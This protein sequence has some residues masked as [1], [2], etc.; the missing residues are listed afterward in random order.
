MVIKFKSPNYNLVKSNGWPN[1]NHLIDQIWLT[2]FWP[3]QM[4]PIEPI[5]HR[6]QSIR[7]LMGTFHNKTS[8]DICPQAIYRLCY[9]QPFSIL[10]S[11]SPWTRFVKLTIARNLKMNTRARTTRDMQGQVGQRT[12]REPENKNELNKAPLA[13]K[14]RMLP[15]VII[16]YN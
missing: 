12:K 5:Y 4:S 14:T 3:Y 11:I 1:F 2:N 9:N 10:K 8:I 13:S 7:N 6:K 15:K 16:W